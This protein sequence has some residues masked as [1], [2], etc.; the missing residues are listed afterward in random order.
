MAQEG[1]KDPLSF[2][3]VYG[4]SSES[5]N[6]DS[7]EGTRLAVKEQESKKC[8][9]ESVG[10]AKAALGSRG[11]LPKPDELF[12]TVSKPSF[13]YNPLKKQIDWDRHTVKAPEA[14]PKEF[15]V[16]KTNAVPPPETYENEEKK[17][18]PP[19]MD[20]AIKWSSMYEDNGE[21]APHLAA[22]AHVLPEEGAVESDD[23]KE[24]MHSAKKR[25]LE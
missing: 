3:A 11:A 2:F 9:P 18:P 13:L 8:N 15:K 14:P 7:E 4:S 20:M 22:K 21:D 24:E 10:K 1:N 25:K 17:P 6:S 23:D 16:W 12:K 19:G 5:E